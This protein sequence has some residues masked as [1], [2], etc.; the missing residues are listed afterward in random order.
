MVERILEKGMRPDIISG[1]QPVSSSWI[2]CGDDVFDYYEI[3]DNYYWKK[4]PL[5]S[6]KKMNM[7]SNKLRNF[8]L[9]LKVRSYS[10]YFSFFYFFLYTLFNLIFFFSFLT[11]LYDFPPFQHVLFIP[12]HLLPCF[13]L[14]FTFYHH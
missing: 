14:N 13:Q 8:L 3:E 7:P 2:N 10:I 11:S 4:I 5:C 12:Y 9:F 6:E 1:K